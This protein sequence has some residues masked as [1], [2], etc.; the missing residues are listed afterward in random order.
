[1]LRSLKD[2]VKEFLKANP[3]ILY[4][5]GAGGLD[6][7]FERFGDQTNRKYLSKVKSELLNEMDGENIPVKKITT[8]KTT[9]LPT[10]KTTNKATEKPAIKKDDIEFLKEFIRQQRKLEGTLSQYDIIHEIRSRDDIQPRSIR[11]S[12]KLLQQSKQKAKET[13]ITL[14]D[15]INLA[16]YNEVN[17]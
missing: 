5:R 7:L 9:K 6:P 1:M 14:Q 8:E 11:I 4:A 16:I 13:G 3:D 15:F 2:E 10:E 12:K 17:K